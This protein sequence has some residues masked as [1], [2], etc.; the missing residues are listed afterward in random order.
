MS[1]T[2]ARIEV[3]AG[4]ANTWIIGDD[5]EVIV[6][7]PAADAAAVQAAVGERE[8]LAV[9]CTHGHAAHTEAALEVAESDEAPVAVHALDRAAW[10]EV[11]SS[12]PDIYMEDGGRFEV[13]GVAL[14]VVHAPGHSRGSVL[15]YCEELAVAFTG[16]VVTAAGPVPH[17]GGFSKLGPSARRHRRP[18]ADL[19]AG[20]PTAPRARRGVHRRGCGQGVQFVVFG[21]PAAGRL[22]RVVA[23]ARAA[24]RDC[25]C[26]AA[27]IGLMEQLGFEGMPR[28]LYACTPT[29][30]SDVAELPATV[31]D[32]RTWTGRPR[33]RDRRGPTT[34]SAPA[35]TTRCAGWWRLPRRHRTVTA[36]GDLLDQ[37]WLTDGFADDDQ[38]SAHRR[39]CRTLVENYVAT[40]DPAV[41]PAGVERTVAT[42][43]EQIAVSGR[44]DRLDDRRARDLG[45]SGDAAVTETRQRQ[46]GLVVVDYKTGRHQLTVDDA[47]SSLALALYALA[48]GRVLRRPCTPGGTAPSAHRHGARLGPHARVPEP[49]A[50]PGRGHRGRVRRRRPALPG[51][52]GSR[53]WPFHRRDLPATAG[54]WLRLV[55]L[56]VA[57]SG[58]PSGRCPSP[59]L[60][61]P[62]GA[63]HG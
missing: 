3:V 44:I 13:G 60:G 39:R 27:R 29:R 45:P 46:S 17:S 23:A 62:R 51:P 55:R 2:D 16:D 15:L 47:R 49:A 57:V 48:A 9:I 32:E 59:A 43:T 37:G 28:R 63:D 1:G 11:H 21:R 58:G 41:E 5:D 14:E 53:S 34:A 33:R 31:P 40:L 35:C 36:A 4:R 50:R 7:D 52:A 10:R 22:G 20:D 25:R 30:L 12:D 56:P 6:V 8:I 54:S 19:A 42:R 26:R 38:S 61:W 24:A 18:R